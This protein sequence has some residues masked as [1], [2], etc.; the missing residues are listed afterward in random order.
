ME[1]LFKNKE[2]LK[3]IESLRGRIDVI[4]SEK[5]YDKHKLE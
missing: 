2:V 4:M 3:E 5:E 1:V